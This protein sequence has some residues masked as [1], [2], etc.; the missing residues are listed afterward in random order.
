[1]LEKIMA[2]QHFVEARDALPK[3]QTAA[4]LARGGRL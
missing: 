1:M 2:L 4:T 3:T